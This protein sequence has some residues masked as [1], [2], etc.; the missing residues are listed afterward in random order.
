[1]S[2]ATTDDIATVD[3]TAEL[4]ELEQILQHASNRPASTDPYHRYEIYKREITA[5]HLTPGAYQQA[6]RELTEALEL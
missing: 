4:A 1:M 5:L 3:H 2:I 6:I